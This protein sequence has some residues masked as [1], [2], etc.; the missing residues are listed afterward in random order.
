MLYRRMHRIAGLR[1]QGFTIIEMLVVITIIMILAG[2]LLPSLREARREARITHCLA[3]LHTFGAALLM[4]S[5]PYDGRSSAYPPWLT[6]LTSTGGKKKFIDEPKSML[7]REDSS[8]GEQG[9]RPDG[10]KYQGQ[11]KPIDQFEMADI[12]EHSGALNGSSSKKNAK[13]GGINCS[14]IFEYSGEPCDWIYTSGPPVTSGTIGGVPVAPTSPEWQWTKKTPANFAEFKSLA[15]AN[16][17]GVLSWNEVKTLSRQG[18][19]EYGLPE[20]GIRVPIARCYWHV[21]GQS[22]LKNDSLVLDLLGDAHAIRR[23][24]PPWFK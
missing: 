12:D 22:I 17:D 15:D 10:M 13:T 5:Q 3:N 2:M 20:W 14:Y 11:T 24:V 23:G 9:G 4:Y 8:A 7:C 16:Q 19:K 6:M 18:N 21:D 1:R